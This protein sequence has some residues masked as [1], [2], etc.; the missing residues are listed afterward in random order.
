MGNRFVLSVSRQ[1][2]LT[3]ISVQNAKFFA[4][5]QA[6]KELAPHPPYGWWHRGYSG[7]G[8][9]KAVQMVFDEA[10]IGELRKVPDFKESFE[11]GREDD[12]K[13]P[14]IWLPEEKLPGFRAFFAKFFEQG[15][16]LEL[17]LLRAIAIG[18]GLDDK[19]FWPYHTNKDNQIRLLHY[20]PVEESLI[21]D[22]KMER[23]SGHTD[24]GTMTLLF[25]DAVGGLEVEDIHEKGKFTSATPIPGTVVVNI[26]D[27][28][29]RWSNDRLKSTLHRVRAPPLSRTGFPKSGQ[30]KEG[31]TPARYSI[32]YFVSA[33]RD[34]VID[35]LPGCYGPDNPKKYEPINSGDYVS[36][37]LNATY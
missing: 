29:Q 30:T 26:G 12:T 34:K 9:E 37:R 20:P 19:Y 4:L 35:C 18:M 11:M 3:L 25:Q 15:Y 22:G 17:Q 13:T 8:R 5:P 10:I 2:S 7:V 23:V 6:T 32:P 28:L 21:R 36:M 1:A 31:I 27:F 33:D 24:F 16:Q 14:N